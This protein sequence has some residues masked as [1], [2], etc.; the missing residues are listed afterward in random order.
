ML[1]RVLPERRLHRA[2]DGAPLPF[3][4]ANQ[5][6]LA[7]LLVFAGLGGWCAAGASEARWLPAGAYGA[8]TLA[9]ALDGFL[10]R[11]SGLQSEFGALFDM[12]TDALGH[13][14]AA[15]A[16]AMLGALPAWGLLLGFAR[17]LYALGLWLEG[18]RRPLDPNPFRRRLAGFQ[19]GLLA[20]CL[21]PGI[22]PRWSLPAALALGVPFLLS[23]ARDYL[24]V[25][26]RL[27]PGAG[28]RL[29]RFRRPAAAA[30]LLAALVLSAFDGP[31]ALGAFL[32]GWLLIG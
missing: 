12:E 8:A 32:L 22:T 17:Y 24:V 10:A 1:W 11:R 28:A 2:A 31:A 7:R 29:A 18:A 5:V 6:T 15:T 14:A 3:G 16:A 27:A 9:D 20:V 19:M 23:F 4:P 21:V 13:A 30:A 25:S 26:G